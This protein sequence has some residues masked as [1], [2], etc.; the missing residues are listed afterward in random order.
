MS[1]RNLPL[2]SV[3]LVLFVALWC[4]PS[5]QADPQSSEVVIDDQFPGGNIIV[6][7]IEGDRVDLRPDLRDTQGWWFYWN[8]RVRGAQGRTLTFRFVDR[9]PIG[10]R[11]PAV[12]TDQ[13]LT[14]SWLGADRV[15]DASFRYSFAA[16]ADEVRFCFAM[17]Y[18]QEHFERFLADYRDNRYLSVQPLCTSRAG[19][20]IERLHVGDIERQP[21]YRIFLAAR[22]HACESMAS[23]T[24]EGFVA[25]A[26]ADTDDGRWF[27]E[28]V[29]LLAVPFVDKDGVEQG[30]QGKNRKP[31][32]HNRDYRGE[33]IY[34]SVAAIRTLLPA[35]SNGRL[36]VAFDLHCPWIRGPYNE[37]I[38][39]VGSANPEIWQRQTAFGQILE[40]VQQGPLKYRAADNLPF[41]KA[42]NTDANYGQ[43]VSFGRWASQLEGIGLAATFEIPYANAAG[44]VVDADSARAFGHDLLRAIRQ[45]VSQP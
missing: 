6:E 40:Q 24:L 14:W 7:R 11:G 8:F 16:D 21:R 5:V 27:R 10:V 25:A 38:Y 37:V 35:W 3:V 26:L 36:D 4:V 12:S 43:G 30:D 18:Q 15:Q 2:V 32:D 23:Y 44:G 19:R 45:F 22:H 39:M 29:H 9:N 13:G 42:W 41:G 1:K 20:S 28:H 33:S 31:H 34:P 17:P